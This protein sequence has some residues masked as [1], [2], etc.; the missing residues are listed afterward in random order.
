MKFDEIG[1]NWLK[2]AEIGWKWKKVDE[3][4][5]KWM[6]VEESGW[7]FGWKWMKVDVIYES[8]EWC[9]TD[10]WLMLMLMLILM[11]MLR[12]IPSSPGQSFLNLDYLKCLVLF[13]KSR[14]YFPIDMWTR[15]DHIDKCICLYWQIHLS[16]I[17]KCICLILTNVFVYSCT[18][19]TL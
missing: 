16:C 3:S 10:I 13:I 7:Q 4:G 2:L 15:P 1:Y 18:K 8:Y 11:L 12:S 5:W 17:D 19:C 9:M 14:W 6:K